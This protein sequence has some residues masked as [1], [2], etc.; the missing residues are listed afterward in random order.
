MGDLVLVYDNLSKVNKHGLIK[1]FKNN[2]SYIV[3]IDNCDKHISADNMRLIQSVQTAESD[4]NTNIN[5]NDSIINQ[6]VADNVS[7]PNSLNNSII[8]Q[9]NDFISD[10]E[11]I[12]SSS[13]ISEYE[14]PNSNQYVNI[15]PARR[16]YI[17][18]VDKLNIGIPSNMSKTRSGRI[19]NV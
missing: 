19:I 8:D 10:T 5:N 13:D 15:Q 4:K 11:S 1:A 6:A 16:K 14:F 12:M 2:N 9:D 3:S 7:K 17:S 18:E